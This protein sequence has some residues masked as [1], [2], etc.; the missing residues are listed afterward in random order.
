MKAVDLVTNRWERTALLTS[1]QTDCWIVSSGAMKHNSRSFEVL[2][3]HSTGRRYRDSWKKF[4]AFLIRSRQLP[5]E[6]K[7]ETGGQI[8]DERSQLSLQLVQHQIW[9]MFDAMK[10][11]WPPV[12]DSRYAGTDEVLGT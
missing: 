8:P 2:T 12:E 4:I 1:R 7:Q 3:E 9:G 6:A 10:G 5:R 11:Q